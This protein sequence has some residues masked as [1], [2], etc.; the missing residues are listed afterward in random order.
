LARGLD[1]R[2]GTMAFAIHGHPTEWRVAIDDGTSVEADAVVLTCP[3]PQNLALAITTG[4]ELPEELRSV[5][6]DRTL[7]L[8]ALLDGPSGVPPPGGLQHPD[9][10]F[11][12]VGDNWAKGVSQVPALTLHAT[13]EWSLAHWDDDRQELEAIL[14]D[15]TAPYLDGA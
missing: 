7:A 2:C 12:F 15:A 13:S 9:G 11:A 5:G 14:R 6:Y 3:M 10:T 1:V 4:A 8:L